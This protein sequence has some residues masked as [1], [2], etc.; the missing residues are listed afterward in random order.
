MSLKDKE[1]GF[2]TPFT[3]VRLLG[4]LFSILIVAFFYSALIRPSAEQFEIASK[5]GVE[6]DAGSFGKLAVILKDYEQQ[7][8]FTLMLWVFLIL[9]Y[10]Y[11]LAHLEERALK[12]ILTKT[13][14]ENVFHYTKTG[15]IVKQQAP[16]LLTQIQS[17]IQSN[18]TMHNKL[19]P[20]LIV[21]GL[22]RFISTHSVQESSDMIKGRIDVTAER[23]ESELS[24]VRY[25][26]WAIP[27]IGFIGTVRGIGAALS[28][29]EMALEGDISGVTN[30]LGLAFNSTLVALFISI[31]LM[32]FI[33]LVQS[34]QDGLIL[35]IETFCREQLID[36]LEIF[37]APSKQ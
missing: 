14:S 33:H 32:Y 30:S 26:A 37:S 4:L 2:F 24:I 3:M 23:L 22:Q 16:E 19:L 18:P 11:L 12:R 36:R 20:H 7:A 35:T 6:E 9:G 25:I 28:K 5:Y 8:C 21:K 27:S 29:A 1:E 15:R 31:F 13:D 10:K 34:K 17:E